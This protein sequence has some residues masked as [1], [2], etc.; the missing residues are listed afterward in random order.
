MQAPAVCSQSLQPTTRKKCSCENRPLSTRC[1]TSARGFL[2]LLGCTF[3]TACIINNYNFF[4]IQNKR[5]S[6][7]GTFCHPSE[8]GRC[9][10][11][12]EPLSYIAWCTSEIPEILQRSPRH[13]YKMRYSSTNTSRDSYRCTSN[14]TSSFLTFF[15][16]LI[17]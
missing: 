13:R 10:H 5:A 4:K 8:M 17:R 3:S 11:I 9:I 16:F 7:K 2:N 14:T 12:T 15:H 6:P 1:A